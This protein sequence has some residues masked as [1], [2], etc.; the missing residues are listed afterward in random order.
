MPYGTRQNQ[1][2]SAALQPGYILPDEFSLAERLCLSV[3][4]A[5]GLRFAGG[6]E[7]ERWDEVLRSDEAVLLAELAALPLERM[8]QTFLSALS[9]EA[10]ESLWRQLW[11][12]ARRYDDM[13]WRLTRAHTP[14][15]VA[16]G[17]A[18]SARI[19]SGLGEL[20]ARGILVFGVGE[21]ELHPAWAR[22]VPD[23]GATGAEDEAT[24]RQLLRRCW[25]AL[26]QALGAERDAAQAAFEQSLHSGRHDPAMGLLLAALQLYQVSRAP[27]NRFPERLID[28]YYR[29][30]LRLR[31]RPA[32]AEYV[33]LLLERDPRYAGEVSIAAGMRFIGGEDANGRAIAFAADGPLTLS[34]TRIQALC[35]VRV[36]RDPLISPECEFDYATRVQ[37]EVLPPQAPEAAYRPRP[38]WWPV[39]G[40]QAKGSAAR[41]EDAELGLAVA[42]PLLLLREGR[43]EVRLRLRFAHPADDDA[44]LARALRMPVDRRDAAW[45]AEV[46]ARYAAH[47]WQH[48]PPR[49]RP[50]PPSALDVAEMARAAWARSP[51][52]DGDGHVAFL[53]AACLAAKQAGIFAER[54]GRLFAAWLIALD[55]LRPEDLAALRAHAASLRDPGQG[56]RAVELDDPL[57]LIY[58]SRRGGAADR[59]DRTLIFSR[60]FE[61]VWQAHLSVADGWLAIERVF[62]RRLCGTT[63]LGGGL[64]LAL[65]LGPEQPPIVA[66]QPGVHGEHWPAQAVLQLRLR[67]RSRLYAYSLLQQYRLCELHLDVAVRDARHLVLYNQLG[68]LDPSKPFQPFGPMPVQGNYMLL[69]SPE[70][71]CKP[72]LSL[73][74]RL[75][76]SGLPDGPGGLAEHYA[77][78]PGDWRNGQFRLLPQLLVDGQWCAERGTLPMF[79]ERRGETRLA[80]ESQLD[81]PR[82][83]LR[84]WQRA[85]PVGTDGQPFL[86]G[87]DSRNGF[88]RFELCEPAGAFGHAAYPGLL[89]AALTRNARRKRAAPLPREPYTPSLEGVS[90]SYQASLALPL[91]REV[92]DAR[93]DG[94]HLA[95]YHLH[96]FG[97]LDLG[98]DRGGGYPRLLPRFAHDG[99]LFVGLGGSDPQGALS[100]LFHLRKE[101]AAERLRETPPALQWSAWL[102]DGWRALAPQQQLADDT[103]GML[104]TGIVQLNLP[105]DMRT[106]CAALPARGYWLRLGA[107]WGFGQLAGLYGVH[108]HAIRATRCEAASADDSAE[109]LAPDSV[110]APAQ[111]LA[112]LRGVR[113]VG[114]SAGRRVADPPEALR[115]RGAE[116]LRHKQRAITAW[117]YERLLLDAFPEVHKAKCLPYHPA[118]ADGLPLHPVPGQVLVVVVPHPHRGS[119]FSST[120]APRLDADAI[121]A[122]QAYLQARAPSGARVWVRNA[123]YE[124]VQ[125]RGTLRLEPGRHAGATLRRLNQALVEFLSPWHTGGVE[126]D[127]DSTLRAE[128]IEAFLR[129]QDDVAAVGRLALLHIARDD[130]H[131]YRLRDVPVSG[132]L[133]GVTPLKPWSLLLP[134]R[135]HL[136][137]VD[138]EQPGLAPPA[139]GID[140]LEIGATFI[141]GRRADAAGANAS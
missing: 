86:Y 24:R 84:R 66:C 118:S 140:R 15:A 22:Q 106:D 4:Q 48:F 101:E 41:A 113:Q 42:S 50:T 98:H 132:E 91:T 39:L 112:G 116:R 138:D 129:A 80:R 127:F 47:E 65:R 1:R 12:F 57:I 26:S 108:A 2:L 124:R 67:T 128:A 96:P 21:G 72:L 92:V 45:V 89:G 78:Y 70:L 71:A 94:G 3:A 20:W 97:V 30:V 16:L 61:Q 104:R 137:R 88:F 99:N 123:A 139:T 90:L 46:F 37:A 18:L 9:W 64:T 27:L 8:Q 83:T 82:D 40:G 75:R 133:R 119:L 53:L 56:V 135:Q 28:F 19:E 93:R 33:H 117:D 35:S 5:A 134:V 13:R 122:M 115:L 31:P 55:D 14:A 23:A 76:W 105:A 74:L 136:L 38:A 121:V 10:P 32:A 54:L 85:I 110:N 73:R 17:Q 60:V 103:Q 109:P 43:R 107:D 49:P 63:E 29:D 58:P 114:Q 51:R 131:F 62:V 52:F 87:L 25:L 59:P 69:G 68:R 102:A 36:E 120:E 11:A 81:F 79:A 95:V 100:L 34:D 141:V 111:S 77:A 6:A 7:H 44:L 125:V 130:H 126:A